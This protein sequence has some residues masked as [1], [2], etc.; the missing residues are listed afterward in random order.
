MLSLLLLCVNGV[1]GCCCAA[2]RILCFVGAFV[3]VACVGVAAIYVAML[4]YFTTVA[5]WW[6]C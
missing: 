3:Y 4:V 5:V 6:C 2:A 1:A